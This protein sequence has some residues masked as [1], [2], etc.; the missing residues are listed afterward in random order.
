M[1]HAAIIGCGSVAPVHAHALKQLSNVELVACADTNIERAQ[2]MAGEYN[3]RAYASM[4]ELLASEQVQVV[5]LCTP[6]YLHTPMAEAAAARGI[7]VFTE[8]PMA[9]DAPGVRSVMESVEL[10]KKKNLCVVA[11]FCWRYDNV[12]R[13][14]F[15]QIHNGAIGEL[16]TAYGT[17]LANPVKPMPPATSRPARMSNLEWMVRNWYNFTF[18]SGDGLVEQA[19]HTVDWLQW[20]MKDQ[21]SLSCTAVGGRQIPQAGGNIFDHIE[22]N[23][24][25]ENGVR[26]FL[27]QRHAA[28][29]EGIAQ[30]EHIGGDG[31]AQQRGG[32]AAGVDEV[33]VAGAAGLQDGAARAFAREL[34]VRVLDEGGGGGAGGVDGGPGAALA[35]AAQGVAAGADDGKAL[36][37]GGRHGDLGNSVFRQVDQ[38]TDALARCPEA[39]A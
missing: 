3:I 27:A 24:L 8:K 34:P 30:H 12:K 28:L 23:Y 39:V 33:D 38:G 6:H 21:P 31:V 9:T 18:L 37:V 36:P 7:H 16:H 17:Y 19:V 22:V 10:A 20:V 11:G 2:R 29:L 5:H 1:I 32:D 35:H 25:W 15:E 14:L 4:E 26:G 13:A